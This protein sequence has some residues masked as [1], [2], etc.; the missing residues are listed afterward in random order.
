MICS[1]SHDAP[2]PSKQDAIAGVDLSV[3]V[4]GDDVGVSAPALPLVI[5]S[6]TTR[7]LSVS[8]VVAAIGRAKMFQSVIGGVMVKV[9]NL[10]RLLV[11]GKEPRKAVTR[12]LSAFVPN[13]PI[14]LAVKRAS[15]VTSLDV[16]GRANK[17]SKHA[18][19]RVVRQDISDRFGYKFRSHVELPLSVVRGA[20]VGATVAPILT[21]ELPLGK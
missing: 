20:V 13:A 12:V 18:R 3:C 7:L 21:R 5:P 15:N 4:I 2:M 1:L 16:S 17:P 19:F 10:W 8:H 14:S 11:M 6:N 9:V